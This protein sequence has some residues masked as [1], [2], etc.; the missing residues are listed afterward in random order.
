MKFLTTITQ[1]FKN[2]VI[3]ALVIFAIIMLMKCN[4]TNKRLEKVIA[5]NAALNEQK[6]QDSLNHVNERSRWQDSIA[7]AGLNSDLQV[8]V[9]KETE[10][11]LAASQSAVNRLTA[12]IR[13]E[14]DKP[15]TLKGVMVSRKYKDACDSIPNKID[16][17]NAVIAALHEN[18]EGLVDLMNYETVYRD[19]L[20]EVEQ[21]QVRKLNNTIAGKNK[22]IE[23][24]LKAG[25]PRG[26][27]LLGV[28]VLGNEN[29]FLG[30]AS[31]KAAY[32]TKGGKMYMYSPHVMQLP[33]MGTPAVFHE[34][35]IL[36][37]PF[38]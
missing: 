29:K 28:G 37:N 5:A 20:I 21:E 31:I 24:A 12:I 7:N 22:I 33:G 8:K 32:L 23:D 6:K 19:S 26:M 3:I 10:K 14:P 35:S 17:Q 25:R 15:D 4:G 13:S 36:F 27:F 9:I 11:K 30:G 16:S 2:I 38:K 34:A 18:N 1:N